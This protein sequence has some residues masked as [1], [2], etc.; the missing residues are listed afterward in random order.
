M[1]DFIHITDLHILPPGE[2]NY[3][4]DP[5]ERLR[6]AV[7]SIAA[8]HGPGSAAPAQFVVATGDLT[9]HGQPAAYAQLR[10]ILE[11]LPMPFHLMLGNHD[12]RDHFRDAFPEQGVDQNGFV[13]Q[14]IE[15]DSGLFLLLDTKTEGTHAG[16]LCD[17]RLAWLNARL[18][19]SEGPVFLFLHHPP[20]SVGISRMDRIQ[21]ADAAALADVLAPHQRRIR[22]MFHGH[23]HRPL[24]GSWRGIPFS[25]IRGTAHQVALDLSERETV[26]GSHEPAAY[27]LV[28]VSEDAVIVHS[29]DYLDQTN[30]F[31]L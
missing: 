3:G 20:M 26:P 9:H 1:F 23:L 10:E 17:K 27:A 28:R 29:H 16:A 25:S 13:Q 6:M 11:G 14:A 2:T 8:R 15:T 18:A 19:E 12:E 4:L 30:H 22:H 31:D 21:M 5:A 24:A 7:E